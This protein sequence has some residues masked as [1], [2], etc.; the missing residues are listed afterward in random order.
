MRTPTHL[1]HSSRETF[2][3]CARSWFLK[4][5][6][7]APQ[8]PALWLAGGSAVHEAT[9]H[10]DLMSVVGNDDVFPARQVWETY[11][12]N[13]LEQLRDKEE[14]EN[15]WRRS[16]DIETWRR[17][18]LQF[19]QAY[20]DWRERSPWEIW[21]TPEG[22]PAIELDVGGRLPG[23]PVEIKAIIDRVFWDPVFKKH[24]IVDL[25]TSKKPPKNADQFG[26]YRALL[27]VRYDIDADSG[28]PFMNRRASLGKPFDLAEYTPEYVGGVFGDAWK[29]IQEY[30]RTGQWPANTGDCFICDVS[31]SCAAKNGP[32]AHLYDPDSLAYVA[33]PG[34]P[35][36]S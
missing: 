4:Y 24:H 31:A 12:N 18:G 7:E 34:D 11:F 14:N 17:M 20:I 25:K 36:P 21:T 33:R 22:E 29:Q 1:S 2:L 35:V 16:E 26:T 27:K 6:A 10:Y 9:E 8:T 28:V 32:L 5:L 3:R 19:V 15:R 23:C 13:Q 30:T